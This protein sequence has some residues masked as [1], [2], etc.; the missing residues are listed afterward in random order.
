MTSLVDLRAS[1]VS[2]DEAIAHVTHE[3][4]GGVAVFIGVVRATNE[5]RPVVLLEYEAYA[6]MARAELARIAEEIATEVVGVRLAALHRTGPLRVGET[7]V[8][9]AASA[10][11]R[12]EA[13]RACRLLIDRIK[14]R[15]PI[16]KREHGPEG[17]YWVGWTDAR[18]GSG[19]AHP[20]DAVTPPPPEE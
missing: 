2:A 7:A 20:G 12:D 3:G 14:H 17:A 6:P 9:C 10:V 15:V 11:H 19:H 18:C 13:F 5:G 8:V 16:W 1:V 4:A